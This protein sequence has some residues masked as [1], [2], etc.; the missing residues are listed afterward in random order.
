VRRIL[1]C[2]V[3]LLVLSPLVGALDPFSR[4]V[5]TVI[6]DAGHGGQD[7]G[8]T[9]RWAFHG[10]V[11]QEKDLTLDIAK[12]TAGLLRSSHPTLQVI[13]TRSDDRYVS[14]EERSRIASSADL[15]NKGGLFVSIHVNSAPTASASG[16]EVL[17]KRQDKRIVL[18]DSL[19]P[20]SNIPLYSGFNATELNRL[21]N[22]RN[23]II[24]S[25]FAQ[26]LDERLVTSRNRG[27]KEQDLWVLNQSRMPSVM[28]EVGFLTNE[29]DARDLLSPQWRQRLAQAL[30]AAIEACL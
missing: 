13:L 2:A 26:T 30:S 24:A 17:T 11:V 22:H 14:L 1:L 10:S 25:T 12:R 5:G 4:E 6:I 21:L 15:H 18:L 19:T 7:P 8:A 28:V 9:Y 29:G 20:L 27:V 16:F 23:L 3:L